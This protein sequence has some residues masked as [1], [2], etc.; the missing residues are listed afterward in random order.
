ML[1]DKILKTKRGCLI[2]GRAGS[3]KTHIAKA[4]IQ[5][6]ERDNCGIIAPTNKAC[7]L[8]K[9]ST[10]HIAMGISMDDDTFEASML[11][12]LGMMSVLI[13]DEISMV[14]LPEWYLL[15]LIKKT[16]NTRIV[17][18]GDFRQCDA[19]NPNCQVKYDYLNSHLL[20]YLTDYQILTL[21]INQR[22]DDIMWDLA[23]RLEQGEN[24]VDQL[25]RYNPKKHVIYRHLCFRNKTRL[26]IN[27]ECQAQWFKHNPKSKSI[28]MTLGQLK[29]KAE[30]K[31]SVGM[32][33]IATMGDQATTIFNNE[34]FTIAKITDTF[35]SITNPRLTIDV[36]L[37]EFERL[38]DMAWAIT[39]HKSQGS[40]YEDAY[41]V[42]EWNRLSW[43]GRDG[44][45]RLRNTAMTRTSNFKDLFI[46]L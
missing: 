7:S 38:F 16:Y 43:L 8:L 30:Y 41:V 3:G 12:T 35:V 32:P 14:T 45:F 42:H 37:K 25:Q 6:L 27:Q 36:T 2:T 46:A 18:L 40:T 13:V 11:K 44:E 5:L 20:K 15:Y 22:S 39:I 4:I 1:V 29:Y 9:G 17:L 23:G 26:Q 33:I 28:K 31:I 34:E 24:L 10:F 19:I 21:N